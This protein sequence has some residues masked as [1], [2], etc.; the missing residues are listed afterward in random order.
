MADPI[1]ETIIKKFIALAAT[2]R[3][4]SGYQT[5]IGA[6]VN[7]AEAQIDQSAI[8]ASNI[9]PSHEAGL[10]GGD[11]YDSDLMRMTI[12][13]EGLVAHGS[14]DASVMYEM[15]LADLRKRFTCKQH[16]I[17][18][19]FGDIGIDSVYYRG[20]AEPYLK[21]VGAEVT[22]CAILLQVT[23]RTAMGDPYN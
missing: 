15:I 5:N 1:R 2:I 7:R 10:S 6:N 14:T 21:A 3:T 20:T 8:P 17:T 13:A 4:A 22:G 12:Q 23:Y 19:V 11:T 18:T 16:D 9:V